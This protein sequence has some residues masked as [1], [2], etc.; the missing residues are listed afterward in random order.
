MDLTSP[1]MDRVRWERRAFTWAGC[2]A[3]KCADCGRM[4]M[5]GEDAVRGMHPVTGLFIVHAWHHGLGRD[6]ARLIDEGMA[7]AAARW[8]SLQERAAALRP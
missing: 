4:V 3:W 6:W 1:L 8:P 2:F 5:P 7:M